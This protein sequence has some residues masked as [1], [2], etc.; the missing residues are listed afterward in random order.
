MTTAPYQVYRKVQEPAVTICSVQ[1]NECSLNLRM[2]GHVARVLG[3][4]NVDE[5]AGKAVCDAP[6]VAR[7][8]RGA[9]VGDS[10]L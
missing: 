2:A 3:R 6:E 8:L 1:L 4:K 9:R 5:Q 10:G 7:A